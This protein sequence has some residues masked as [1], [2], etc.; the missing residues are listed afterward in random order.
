MA[1]AS[2][3][4]DRVVRQM[5]M[6]VERLHAF[7]PAAG[8]EVAVLDQRLELS[9]PLDGGRAQ[10]V[11]IVNRHAEPLHQR[12]GVLAEPLLTGDERIAVVRVFH[13]ALLEIVRHADVVVRTEN[14]AGAFA[15]EPRADRLDF[16]GGRFLLGDQMIET[17]HHQ[18][19][20][21]VE[22]A[23][24]DRQLLTRLIDALVHR[25]R[26]PGQLADQLLE[27]KQ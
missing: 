7:E 21:V 17:E 11:L 13:R 1:D 23:G 19:V 24:V 10:A 26:L 16:L 4:R 9:G 5:R 12:P 18:R 14:Q 27:P 3:G 2:V 22:N 20:G 15:R 25:H 6:E 8:V